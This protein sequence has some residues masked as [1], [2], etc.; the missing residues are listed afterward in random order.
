MN[1]VELATKHQALQEVQS[2][3]RGAKHYAEAK[4]EIF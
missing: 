4:E 1:L 2:Q 3:T